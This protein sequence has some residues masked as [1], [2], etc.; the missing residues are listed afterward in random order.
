MNLTKD[1]YAN[2]ETD[3]LK[4]EHYKDNLPEDNYNDRE[5]LMNFS[6]SD[7]DK[8]DNDYGNQ[9]ESPMERHNDLLKELTN[10]E[11]FLKTIIA[12]WIGL[13][14]NPEEGK[15]VKDKSIKPIM[16]VKCAKWCITFLR[17]YARNNNI[18][19]QLNTSQYN[20]IMDDIEEVS[21]TNIG[22][23]YKEFGIKDN[24]NIKLV[25][26]QLIHVAQLILLGAG[27]DNNYKKLLQMTV[28]RSETAQINN[29]PQQQPQQMESKRSM[30]RNSIRTMFGGN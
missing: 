20:D 18:L 15:Y 7:Y 2:S 17:P 25:Y 12:E 26:N 5:Q 30:I 19:T 1:N 6:E 8:F 27:G 24:G 13:R 29:N 3:N 9:Y 11:D 4:E 22:T 21:I 28:N 16:N 14:W 10:F 23:K